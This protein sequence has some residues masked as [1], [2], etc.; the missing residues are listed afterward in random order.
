MTRF[1]VVLLIVLLVL[2]GA[3]TAQDGASITRDFSASIASRMNMTAIKCGSFE[4]S[5]MEYGHFVYCF[6][7]TMPNFNTFKVAWDRDAEWEGVFGPNL[8]WNAEASQDRYAV[9]GWT[10]MT[11]ALRAN[12]DNAPFD[13]YSKTYS[14]QADAWGFS[15]NVLVQVLFGRSVAG[16][17]DTVTMIFMKE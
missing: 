13:S 6:K 12:G 14:M 7:H 11:R 1:Q 3:A 9:D 10:S 2:P 17:R 15:G 16:D 5:I 4:E 8:E